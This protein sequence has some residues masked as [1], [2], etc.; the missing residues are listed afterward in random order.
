MMAG[1]S[2]IRVYGSAFMITVTTGCGNSQTLMPRSPW[3]SAPQKLRY[4][5]QIGL[6]SPNAPRK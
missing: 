2:R 5:S 1:I 6:S 4:C 3:N